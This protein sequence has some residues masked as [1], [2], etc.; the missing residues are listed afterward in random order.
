ML[1]S[2]SAIILISFIAFVSGTASIHALT[3]LAQTVR[4][5]ARSDMKRAAG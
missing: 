1:T 4:Q 5:K 3:T 2:P